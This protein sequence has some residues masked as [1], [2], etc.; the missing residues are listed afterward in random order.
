MTTNLTVHHPLT[1]ST[2]NA[3]TRVASRRI[4]SSRERNLPNEISTQS[5]RNKECPQIRKGRSYAKSC[6]LYRGKKSH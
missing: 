4:I 2:K 6:G 1:A 5:G 3:T